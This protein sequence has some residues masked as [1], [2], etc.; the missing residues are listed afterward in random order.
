MKISLTIFF[1]LIAFYTSR[2]DEVLN[3]ADNGAKGDAVKIIASAESGSPV[4]GV[5][6]FQV[7]HSD[8]GKIVVLYGAGPATTATNNQDL[9]ASVISVSDEHHLTLSRPCGITST[10]LHGLLGTDNTHAFQRCVDRAYESNTVIMVPGGNY[11]MIPPDLLD[12]SYTMK[13][14]TDIRAAV[15]INKG[16]ITIQGADS[17]NTILTACG[18]WQLK[19]KHV[20][21][22]MLF[23]CRGP[24]RHPEIPLV[25]ENLTMDGGVEYGRLGYRGFPARTTDGSGWDMTHGAVLDSGKQPLHDLK[26]FRKC[27]FQHW[28]GEILKGV[29][30]STNGFVEVSGCDFHD[31]N[32]SAFNFDVSH[33]IDHCTFDHLD[34]AMEFYEGRMDR[35]CV[36]ENSRVTDVRADLVIV[37][38]LT[39]HPAPLYT[40][41]NNDLEASNG[42]G[43][44]LNPAKNVLIE[45]N[46]FSSQRFCI[47]NGLGSQG[48][49][50]C[51]DIVIRGNV[52][53]NA[54]ALF[55]VQCGYRYRMENILIE[56]N[57]ITGRGGLG[58]GW[59]YSTNVTFSNNV[60]TNGAGGL[61]GGRLTG[62]WFLDDLSNRHPATLNTRGGVTNLVSYA[63]GAFNE[64]R[65]YRTNMLYMI[66]DSHPEKIPPTATLLITH[67]GKFPSQ[68]YLSASHPEKKP[69][70]TLIPGNTIT[71]TWTNGAWVLVQKDDGRK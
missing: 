70:V 20:S 40:I 6:G 35:P 69:D 32:A 64:T 51:H 25:F 18:A 67:Q 15:V 54:G 11:L 43:V 27:T 46:R 28:R 36:F 21:R 4:I 52:C 49:D 10:N 71:C 60:A 33:H 55:L 37:G 57:T 9:V 30:G 41:K 39:N 5:V 53:T 12:P 8:E 61:Q 22:G 34:M 42:F 16:G 26:A 24:I 59:G 50:Y 29:S 47:G 44:F 45:S 63:N 19:G 66:D 17:K 7:S 48:T 2:A 68:L 23:E 38:A 62:Q 14:E 1:A 13:S 56:G 65:G 58:S 3:V 31:G